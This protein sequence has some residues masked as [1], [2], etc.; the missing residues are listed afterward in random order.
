MQQNLFMHCFFVA[1]TASFN[2]SIYRV[3]EDVGELT[4]TLE[5]SKPSPCC[6]TIHC[7][8]I[9]ITATGELCVCTY[10]QML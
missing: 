1:I 4:P 6:I 9:N 2:Q 10:V 7:E 5:L 8:L 3:S